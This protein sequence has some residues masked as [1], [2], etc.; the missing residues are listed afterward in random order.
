MTNKH[1]TDTLTD[2]VKEDEVKIEEQ[3]EEG[4]DTDLVDDGFEI[5]Y[6]EA[7]EDSF[8]DKFTD[9]AGWIWLAFVAV[10]IT[11]RLFF[12]SLNVVSGTS[13]D[14]TL[15]DG[16]RLIA[17]DSIEQMDRGSIVVA[18]PNAMDNERIVKRVVAVEGD[19]IEFNGKEI[20]LNGK[21]LEEDYVKEEVDHF[22]YG[23]MTLSEGEVFVM[24]DNRNNSL[25]SRSIGAIS[26]EE[27]EGLVVYR[28]Y[29]FSKATQLN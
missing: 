3:V 24:G 19:T 7:E 1:L 23:E 15:A 18:A 6:K 4:M 17:I 29:P 16:D 25:D 10:V 12:G 14:S 5:V 9:V 21:L 13:M 27:I 2:E 11:F 22:Y 20:Y 26:T 8:F 28:F